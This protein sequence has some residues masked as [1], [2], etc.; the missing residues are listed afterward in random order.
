MEG[1]LVCRRRKTQGGGLFALSPEKRLA[2]AQW[3]GGTD[4][5]KTGVNSSFHIR[6][7]KKEGVSL[8]FK[9]K[10]ARRVPAS[11]MMNPVLEKMEDRI[12]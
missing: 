3:E 1:K 2:A 8:N 6:P 12:R 4:S 9:E 7:K 5:K 11:I 10:S